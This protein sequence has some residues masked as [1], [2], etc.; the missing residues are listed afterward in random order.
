MYC[1]NS[2]LERVPDSTDRDV[3]STGGE[4]VLR[5]T[6]LPLRVGAD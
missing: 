6:V 4:P 5:K 3:I 1:C 2:R